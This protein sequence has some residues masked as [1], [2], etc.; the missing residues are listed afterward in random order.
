MVLILDM[1]SHYMLR[2]HEGKW[3]FLGINTR[4]VTV[5]DE[6]KCLEQ[7]E[8]QILRLTCAPLNELPSNINSMGR[9]GEKAKKMDFIP[10]VGGATLF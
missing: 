6:I 7:V 1:V 2:T 4:F 8:H 5:L 10:I 9:R 3:V